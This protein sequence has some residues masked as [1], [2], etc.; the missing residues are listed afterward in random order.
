MSNT[1][2][3]EMSLRDDF[4]NSALN[5]Y[6]KILLRFTCDASWK[7]HTRI[8][9]KQHVRINKQTACIPWW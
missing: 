9:E 2:C 5:S 3:Q 1:W 4:A 8:E 7:F 6:N